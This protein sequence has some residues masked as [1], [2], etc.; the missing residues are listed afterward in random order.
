MALKQIELSLR[1]CVAPEFVFGLGARK[2]AGKYAKNLGA[3]HLLIVT[4]PGV[5]HF[6]W[7]GDVTD[8]KKKES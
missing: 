8:K 3:K 5:I 7:L 1:K 4:D 6:G 2:L